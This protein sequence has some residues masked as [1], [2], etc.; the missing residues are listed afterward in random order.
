MSAP[1]SGFEVELLAPRGASRLTL[2]EHLALAHGGRVL[3]VWHADDEPSLV[4]GLGLFRTLTLGF[5]VRD[6]DERPLCTVVDDVTLQADLDAAARP[7]P[8]WYRVLTDDVRLQHLLERAC[9]PAD[10]VE[11]VL[12]VVSELWGTPVA[13]HGPVRAVAD[14]GGATVAAAAP[15]GGE[16]ERGCEVVTPVLG[17]PDG[18]D[19]AAALHTL[20]DAAAALG[21]AVPAEAAVHV[22]YDAAPLRSASTARNLV[23]L[24]GPWGAGVRDLLGTNPRCSRLAPL[25]ETLVT[26][27]LDGEQG[28]DLDALAAAAVE[29]GLGKFHDV[30]LTALFGLPRRHPERDTVEVR[31]LPGSIDPAEILRGAAVVER[32]LARCQAPD[33]LPVPDPDDPGPAA[34]R[35]LAALG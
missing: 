13:V 1:R 8:G 15:Q 22:H 30:N 34:D 5:E 25:P 24:F 28:S 12:E 6:G 14:P 20:L 23:R 17:G 31:V 7:A 18:P 9:D 21:F 2:A 3:P 29:G 4:P 26:A 11:E 19:R 32:L 16:R 35:L 10:G 27:A 33:P